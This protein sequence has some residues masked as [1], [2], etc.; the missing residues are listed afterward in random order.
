MKNLITILAIFLF[1]FSFAQKKKSKLVPPPPP[2]KELIYLEPPR[3]IETQETEKCFKNT[4]EEQ[5]DTLTFVTET[6]LEYGWNND[7]ARMI[8]T[9]YNYD[10]IEKAKL[11]KDGEELAIT[12]SMQFIDGDYKI[13]KGN[14]IFTPEK[15]D[16]F[17]T[18]TFKLIYKPKSKKIKSLLGSDK[19]TFSPGD[20][21]QPTISI[22]M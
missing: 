22:G 12:K 19:K 1:C 17:K 11:K 15:K 4:K 8:I 14:I 10:H 18:E 2:K 20:C 7:N 3:S 9:T 21:M 6:M 5:K 16:R 13:E